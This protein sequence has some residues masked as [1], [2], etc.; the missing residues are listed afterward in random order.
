MCVLQKKVLPDEILTRRQGNLIRKGAT[1]EPEFD[2]LSDPD[3]MT[4]SQ[5]RRYYYSPAVVF[6]PGFSE[7]LPFSLRRKIDLLIGISSMS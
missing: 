1:S 4:M 2:T 7:G 6:S 5:K 3:E